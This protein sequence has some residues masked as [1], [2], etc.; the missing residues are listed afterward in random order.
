MISD[1]L[2]F[3]GF[4]GWTCGSTDDSLTWNDSEA[5]RPVP[6]AS[7]ISDWEADYLAAK[8][9]KRQAD[10]AIAQLRLDAKATAMFTALE[11]ASLAQINT[12]V[13]NNFAG[14]NPTQRAFLKL[15][16]AS[17]GMYLREK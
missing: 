8:D 6:S 1:V 9:A 17:A 7:E 4:R 2:T 15:L 3:K 16:A 11:N 14:M 5:G 12:W 10:E 13:D